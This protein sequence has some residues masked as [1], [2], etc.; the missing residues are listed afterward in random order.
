MSC[1]VQSHPL[2]VYLCVLFMSAVLYIYFRGILLESATQNEA[3]VTCL[4]P[5]W[6]ANQKLASTWNKLKARMNDMIS[7]GGL[8]FM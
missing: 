4:L 3:L 1:K 7:N 2:G 6:I 8:S 5:T